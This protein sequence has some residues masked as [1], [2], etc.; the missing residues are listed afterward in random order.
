MNEKTEVNPLHSVATDS[1]YQILKE[2]RLSF[3]VSTYEANKLVVVRADATGVN[4]HFLTF[5]RPMGIAA[6]RERIAVG[7]GGS[8]ATMVNVP[9]A[10]TKVKSALPADA[11]FVPREIQVTGDIDIHEMVWASDGL[12]FVNTRFSC[13]CTWDRQHNFVP[14]WRPPFISGYDMRD[15]CHLNGLGL[16]DKHPRYVSALGDTDTPTGWRA[17]KSAGGLLMDI[18][19]NKILL[20]GLSMPHSPR[21]YKDQ[22]WYLE[23]GHGALCRLDPATGK[24]V[25]LCR[26]PGFTRGLDFVGNYAFIGLSKVRETA[27]FSDIPLTRTVAER[28]CGIWVVD[29]TNGRTVAFLR[30]D[31]AVQEIFAVTILPGMS[32]PEIVAW[33]EP[34]MHSTYVLPDEAIALV[35]QQDD[36]WEEPQ[37]YLEKG[38]QFHNQGR[39]EEAITCYRKCLE[40][41]PGFLPARLNLGITLGD[42]GQYD[43]AEEEMKAVIKAEAHSPEAFNSLG[44]LC[45]RQGN[46]QAAAEYY[47]QAIRLEP[48]YQL[49]RHNLGMT[50]LMLGDYQQGLA[51]CEYRQQP[52]FFAQFKTNH[53]RWD[54]KHLLN[55][56]L[57]LHTEQNDSDAIQFLRFLPMAADC[58]DHLLMVC[59][60]ALQQLFSQRPEITEFHN[61]DQTTPPVFDA[62]LPL[63]SLPHTLA[64]TKEQILQP[65]APYL[66]GDSTRVP[67][68]AKKTPLLRVGLFWSADALPLQ[69]GHK[70]CTLADFQPLLQSEGIEFVGLQMDSPGSHNLA[71]KAQLT[72]MSAQIKDYNDVASIL[73]QV[74][75][76]IAIDSPVAHLAGAMGVPTWALLHHRADW[77][78]GMNG[79]TTAWYPSMRLFRQQTAGLW[80][81]LVLKIVDALAKQRS[82]GI[83]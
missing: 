12:W 34:L 56:T 3:L 33:N 20:S 83:N 64:L 4:T 51:E 53:P 6:D 38:N 25:T 15:R 50:L 39:K 59:P 14:R 65:A 24:P 60:P 1:M 82:A 74:G 52:P 80:E 58:C 40:L 46:A 70:A 79:D 18:S 44:F 10:S 49:A 26:L 31:S 29:I 66:H 54:G 61:A 28:V 69:D 43:A 57:M 2:L 62:Y 32:F 23:S 37:T 5:Q 27:T 63:M 35:S 13:L 30:F 19:N 22:L 81:D 45:Y 78:W 16:R 55:K 48:D 21:W 77:R 9:T 67:L 72:D 73:S 41:Q 71:G 17:N 36:T 8:I 42:L 7:T 11:C 76:C 75:L 68:P 47:R